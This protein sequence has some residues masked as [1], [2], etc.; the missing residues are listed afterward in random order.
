MVFD[1]K[2]YEKPLPDEVMADIKETL[3]LKKVME[4][5]P[6]DK[7]LGAIWDYDR[8]ASYMLTSF[9]IAHISGQISQAD[10]DALKQKYYA[11]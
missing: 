4:N 6:A 3:H 2:I 9:K 1:E 11:V 8:Q 5:T 10:F 7:D